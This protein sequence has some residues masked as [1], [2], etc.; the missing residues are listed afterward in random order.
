MISARIVVSPH[1]SPFHG[2][3][4]VA[5]QSH[6]RLHAAERSVDAATLAQAKALAAT[7][8]HETMAAPCCEMM[9]P[10]RSRNAIVRVLVAGPN[11]DT[12]YGGFTPVAMEVYFGRYGVTAPFTWKVLRRPKP[13]P[14]KGHCSFCRAPCDLLPRGGCVRHPHPR[15]STHRT[16]WCDG[17]GK[18]PLTEA[19][20]AGWRG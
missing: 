1:Y 5:Q 11:G 17:S 7:F 20:L 9:T 12:V 19:E 18:P 13:E 2:L 15:G 6:A 14:S 4:G 16:R 3:T 8:F 10:A